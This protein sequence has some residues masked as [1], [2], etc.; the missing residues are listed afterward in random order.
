MGLAARGGGG[1]AGHR[2]RLAGHRSLPNL[3]LKAYCLLATA[4]LLRLALQEPQ[5]AGGK[6]GWGGRRVCGACSAGQPP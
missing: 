6:V 3:F 1:G 2:L 5:A 4:M